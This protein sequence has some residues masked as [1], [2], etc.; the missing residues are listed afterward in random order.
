ML[1][2]ETINQLLSC[3]IF[4]FKEPWVF[5]HMKEPKILNLVKALKSDMIFKSHKCKSIQIF[6]VETLFYIHE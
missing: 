5:E 1:S 3:L 4:Q 2:I 6:I